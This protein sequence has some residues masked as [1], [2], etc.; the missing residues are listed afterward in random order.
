[1][2]YSHSVPNT[3][4]EREN[5][6]IV[7]RGWGVL[8]FIYAGLGAIALGALAGVI[9]P[10]GGMTTIFA[11][12]GIVLG[13]ALGFVHGWYLNVISPSKKYEEWAQYER[14]RLQEAAEHGRLAY[15]NT[16]PA[17]A[18]EADQMIEAI[19]EDGRAQFKQLGRHS[20]FFIPMQW[21]AV[22]GAVIGFVLIIVGI[23]G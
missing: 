12:L 22:V 7:W 9:N 11:G 18:A 5:T 15:R 21:A 8:V 2:R 10:G 4:I 13:S 1:M 3:P 23:G 16:T 17:T 19:I 20:L 14:P 6:V